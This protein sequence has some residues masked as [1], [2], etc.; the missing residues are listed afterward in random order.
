MFETNF[1]KGVSFS[2]FNEIVNLRAVTDDKT[3]VQGY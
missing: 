1:S 2:W 3:R